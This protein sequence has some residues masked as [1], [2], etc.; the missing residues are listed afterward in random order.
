MAT[1]EELAALAK[2]ATPENPLPTNFADQ[3]ET[4]HLEALE[5][6]TETIKARERELEASRA[7]VSEYAVKNYELMTKT[8]ANTPPPRDQQPKPHVNLAKRMMAKD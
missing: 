4:A 7:K 3:L 6:A 2:A 8:P 5:S 1:I